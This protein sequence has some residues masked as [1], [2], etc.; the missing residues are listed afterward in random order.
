MT[1][2][3]LLPETSL[4]LPVS[5][6]LATLGTS[7]TWNRTA[8]DLWCLVLVTQR[9]VPKVHS[10]RSVGENFLPVEAE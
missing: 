8:F 7:C 1:L 3:F 10:C 9:A 5:T 2:G 4:L 6:R